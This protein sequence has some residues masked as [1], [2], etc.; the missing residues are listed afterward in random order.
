MS[1][2]LIAFLSP[3]GFVVFRDR[4]RVYL[5]ALNTLALQQVVNR[6]YSNLNRCWY[7]HQPDQKPC[8]CS[9]AYI[10]FC[11]LFSTSC[12]TCLF[13]SSPGL[14]ISF[15]PGICHIFLLL[16]TY[17]RQFVDNGL[18]FSI[19]IESLWCWPSNHA[20]PALDSNA[21]TICTIPSLKNGPK[22]PF[23]ARFLGFWNGNNSGLNF[24]L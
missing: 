12:F 2:N 23:F 18:L 14:V 22:S 13:T 16:S 11:V 24:I 10:G 19:W 5:N 15:I 20:Q 9:V 7:I 21:K 17:I 1:W 4:T 6:I 3:S 8:D